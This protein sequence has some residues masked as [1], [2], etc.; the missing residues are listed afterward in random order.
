MNK[1][2]ILILLLLSFNFS[3]SQIFEAVN[4][5]QFQGVFYGNCSTADFNNDGKTDIIFSGATT[6]YTSGYTAV[7]I[8]SN[9]SFNELETEFSQIMYSAIALGD[10]D[11]N[12]YTDV[13]ITGV[14]NQPNTTQTPVFEIY[15]N[16]GDE[17]FT[18]NAASGILP[19]NYGS[20]EIADFNNDG[21][22][23]IL[24]NGFN[25]TS[26][27]TKIYFQDTEGNFTDSGISLMGTYFSDTKLFDANND[28]Y[29]D[30]LIT[31]FNTSYIPDTIL[32]INQGDGNFIEQESGL[33]N[34]Y[35]S[36][37]DVADINGD[38]NLD[39]LLSGMN[40]TY[41]ASLMLFENDGSGF[42]SASENTFTGTYGGASSFVD[43]DND[44]LLDIF[45]IGSNA[46]NQN[47]V[48]LYQNNGDGTFTKDDVNSDLLTG[49]NMSDAV[50]FD[51][52]NDTDL[53]L[54]T[55]G[56]SGNEGITKLYKNKTFSQE[57][58]CNQEPGDNPG[59]IG[60]VTFTY[61]GVQ[62]TYTT[63]RTA[64]GN[65]WIQQNLGSD[66]IAVSA[67]DENAFGDLFQWGRWDD[68]HQLRNSETSTT[69]PSPNNPLGLNGGNNLFY[70]ADPEW[71]IDGTVTDTWQ[72]ANPNTVTAANGCDPCKALGSNWRLPTA[73]E[74]QAVIDAENITNITTAFGSNLK[75]TVAGA[76]ASSG[77]YNAGVRGY[78]WSTTVSDNTN[79]AKYL[80]YSD[81]IVN[82]NA[83][84]FREQGSSIR[85]L[86]NTVN[87]YCDVSVDYDV[88]PISLVDFA[89]I[90]NPT[91]ATIGASD[92]YEDF[93]SM[94]GNVEM[95]E[96]YTLTVKGNTAGPFEHDIRVFIDWNQDKIFDMSS[97][98]YTV[99]LLP[100]TGEDDV[101]ATLDITIPYT[102]ATGNTRMR[103]IKDMWNVYEEGEFDACLN[104]YYG[105]FEDYTVNIQ[106]DLG[107][108][109]FNRKALKIY[110]NPTTDFVAVQSD[111]D[112]KN[113]QVYNQ[114]GQLVI[115]Q[116]ETQIDLS[117][118]AP[119]IYIV[120]IHFENGASATQKIIK[121]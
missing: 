36:S 112:I 81:F 3:N 11:G 65:I 52:D 63:V 29:I 92:P 107:A 58:P 120:Q 15:Y 57:Q 68:G 4:S 80:Y 78:Y 24:V 108:I 118:I 37:I 16:N 32:Y 27:I 5:P 104:A 12:G 54:L 23:D 48:L 97:E 40:S 101:Q 38:G 73:E 28:G 14:R 105:Q 89:D 103:I 59:D 33:E 19:V 100:S 109:D 8:N 84:G 35:F 99:S 117:D 106:E 44:G 55:I 53:D 91:S 69:L 79:F 25:S 1:K 45:S 82:P 39:V 87:D 9:G 114:L 85:C 34:V 95:G 96:T 102:A 66:A 61:N 7:Y 83:G 43:Y 10:I 31:G 17:T 49:L 46:S 20:V 67:T 70:T 72:A 113:L 111:L 119:G 47:V 75:L 51:M 62:T 98:Y 110:P 22:K 42:F 30:I 86:K 93:T 21:I 88:E 13:A 18:K 64:D 71:W 74:W 115:S 50:W 76:R 41:A 60:C 2:Y 56:F 121:K 94:I 90:H 6:S 26:Y 77:V 116:K